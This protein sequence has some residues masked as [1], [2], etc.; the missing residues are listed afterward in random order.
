MSAVSSDC[1]DQIKTVPDGAV[2]VGPAGGAVLTHLQDAFVLETG[3]EYQ[4]G[5]VV[6]VFM[7]KTQYILCVCVTCGD[8]TVKSCTKSLSSLDRHT[9]SSPK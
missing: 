8:S 2:W 4:K 5:K 7:Y 3:K 6:A 1:V 9:C